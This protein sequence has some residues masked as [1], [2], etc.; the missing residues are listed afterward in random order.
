MAQHLMVASNFR[1]IIENPRSYF[2]GAMNHGG[3]HPV[4]WIVFLD[5]SESR[6]SASR[7][8]ELVK[9]LLPLE[10]LIHIMNDHEE[11]IESIQASVN[12]CYEWLGERLS[13]QSQQMISLMEELQVAKGYLSS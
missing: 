6:P 1:S 11:F 5:K 4:S 12:A 7:V 9:E 2:W 13:K 10:K 8:T 3:V